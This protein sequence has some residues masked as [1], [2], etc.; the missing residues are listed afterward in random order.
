MSVTIHRM[1]PGPR[2]PPLPVRLSLTPAPGGL[3]GVW[4]PR[5]RALTRELPGLTAALDGPWGRV[6]EVV[7]SPACWPVVPHWVSVRGRTVRVD[8]ATG[9]QD[10]H[11]LTLK[12]AHGRRDVL[13]IPP[14][15]G[16][17]RARR[18]LAEG[19]VGVPDPERTA[20]RAGARD[21]RQ[22]PGADDSAGTLPFR[23]PR[24]GLARVSD[25]RPG[26]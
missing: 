3:D 8:S 1:T 26:R 12:C 23:V 18:L 7:I 16:A 9:T 21:V 24:C 10:P 5:S 11:R 2:V 14:E 19:L 17:Q 15:A 25:R 20:E 4:W 6:T 22:A 13:V